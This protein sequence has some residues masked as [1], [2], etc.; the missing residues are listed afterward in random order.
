LIVA[1][2]HAGEE[3]PLPD[4]QSSMWPDWHPDATPEDEFYE[5]LEAQSFRRFIK[6]H[7]PLDGLPYFAQVKYLVIGRDA[8]DVNGQ[9]PW[10]TVSPMPG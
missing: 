9:S 10:R 7:L 2:L 3:E 4:A 8:R 5:K 1:D 6:T